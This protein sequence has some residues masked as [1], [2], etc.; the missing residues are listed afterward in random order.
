MPDPHHLLTL[1]LRERQI[2]NQSE[3]TIQAYHRDVSDFLKFCT[4]KALNLNDVEPAD[5]RQY[6]AEKVEIQ[7]LSRSSMQRLLSSIR[8]FMQWAQQGQHLS[9]NPSQDIRFKQQQRP[10][11][12]LLDIELLQQVLDQ[13]PPDSLLQQQL[14]LRDKAMLELMYGAGIRVS[15]L[16]GLNWCDVDVERKQLRVL[17]KGKKYRLS[18]FGQKA[19]HSLN[20]WQVVAATWSKSQ[21]SNL[22]VFI[23]QKAQRLTVRQIENRVSIQAKRAGIASHLH[24]HLLRHCFATHLLSASGDLRGVQ[25]L[26]GHQNLSTTQIYTHVDFAKLAQVYDQSHP[27]AQKKT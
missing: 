13:P 15:E 21:D 6:F 1:W 22:P 16:Q 12:G 3:H 2:Q 14:W 8:Q 10:L 9:I 17:G 26:L 23:S 7:Q 20:A 11:P 5:L 27:R 18:P 25:E 19:L 24:P 4:I